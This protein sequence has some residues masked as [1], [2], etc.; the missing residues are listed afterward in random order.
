MMEATD[1]IE[2]E[3][4]NG[5]F[6]KELTTN[7]LGSGV[8]KENKIVSNGAAASEENGDDAS[9]TNGSLECQLQAQD[10]NVSE[11]GVKE[12]SVISKT[13]ASNLSKKASA[14]HGNDSKNINSR[15]VQKDGSGRIGAAVTPKNSKARL[16]QS[17][18]FPA[19]S[20]TTSGLRK[21][22]ADLKQA[23]VD[24]SANDSEIITTGITTKR[25]NTVTEESSQRVL[26]GNT[27]SVDDGASAEATQ[28][29]T[30]HT[31]AQRRNT[32]GFSFRLEERAEKRKEYFTKLEEKINAKELEKT[33]IQAKSK[34]NQEA[35]IRQLRKSL[36]FKAM[37]MPSFYQE[38]SPPKV[39]LKKIPPTRARSPKLGRHKPSNPAADNSSEVNDPPTQTPESDLTSVKQN[40]AATTAR[41]A[42]KKTAAHKSI[43]R[44]PSQKSSSSTRPE[45][46]P[47]ASKI[48]ASKTKQKIENAMAEESENRAEDEIKP[49]VEVS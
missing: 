5:G 7:G 6:S 27:G 49:A 13:R 12:S 43:P 24:A 31:K 20:F 17:L 37:P 10:V 42:P 16:S 35:E 29:L 33:N 30:A 48:K 28:S 45:T 25:E 15:N 2:L 23:K 39:E 1:G 47:T 8:S 34:E 36:T 41:D 40:G 38:P 22:T 19:K 18:S 11:T 26:P 3:P 44:P 21:S 46:K 14:D 32:S 9:Q 4:S